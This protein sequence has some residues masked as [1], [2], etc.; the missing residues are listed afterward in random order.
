MAIIYDCDGNFGTLRSLLRFAFTDYLC[1][2]SALSI[3][4]DLAI[5]TAALQHAT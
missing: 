1:V 3:Q 2:F 5:A 4:P